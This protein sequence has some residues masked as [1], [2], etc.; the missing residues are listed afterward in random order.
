MDESGP[1]LYGTSRSLCC[2]CTQQL[3]RWALLSNQQILCTYSAQE[4]AFRTFYAKTGSKQPTTRCEEVTLLLY[5]SSPAGSDNMTLLLYD[6]TP[7]G[8]DFIAV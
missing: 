3:T 5:D 2:S 7:A 8:S 1:T 4:M 6:S